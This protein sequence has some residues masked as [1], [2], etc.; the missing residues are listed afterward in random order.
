MVSSQK[1]LIQKTILDLKASVIHLSYSFKKVQLISQNK[2]QMSEE[3]L[4]SWEGFVSRFARVS[5]LFLSKYLRSKIL[6]A[7]PAFR[8]EII[9]LLNKAEKMGLIESADNWYE[10]RALRNFSVHEY[11]GEKFSK[12]LNRMLQLT[13]LLIQTQNAPE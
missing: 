9:D 11:A 3:N 5:D 8:G 10:I 1:D 4:E 6:E 2:A 13:P 12:T 7:D